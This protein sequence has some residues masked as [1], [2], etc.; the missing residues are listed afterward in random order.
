MSPGM[1]EWERPLWATLDVLRAQGAVVHD[2]ADYVFRL[3]V[4]KFL[5]DVTDGPPT[6][7]IPR[8]V[9][10]PSAHWS[11]LRSSGSPGLGDRVNKACAM[12]E[13]A[14]PSLSRLLTEEDFNSIRL[15]DRVLADL[16]QSLS[17]LPRLS[18]E[19]VSDGSLGEVANGFL[20]RLVETSGREYGQFYTPPSVARLMAELLDPRENMRIYDPFCGVGGFLV[21]CMRRVASSFGVSIPRAA[22]SLVLHGQEKNA[23]L[24]ALC[25]MNLL[26]HG[27][28][29]ARIEHGNALWSPL[30][31]EQGHMLQY[32]RVVADPPWSLR[33]WGA[34]WAS[35]DAFGRF[36][37]IP[38]RHGADYA[39][40]QHCLAALAEGGMAALLL[41]RGVLFR[42]GVE[43]H[44]R[45]KLLEEDRFEAI[46]GLPVNLLYY[47]S[48][49]PVVLILRKGKPT[50]RRNRVLFIDAS[51]AGG[52]K[53]RRRALA[54]EDI[55]AIVKAFQDFEGDRRHARAVHL[56]EIAR[57]NWNL[58]IER[59]VER[60]EERERLMLDEQL[61]ALA[62]AEK[63]RE[64]AARR[65]DASIS[66]LKRFCPSTS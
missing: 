45:R 14:N 48:I 36:D 15:G 53:G 17:A 24:W 26:L 39:F 13:E 10:P 41:P 18:G 4:L 56:D 64:E 6:P 21:E 57:S 54:R 33:D 66:R 51:E 19:R 7:G 20:H 46:I 35:K 65:M 23:E 37:P 55:G 40:V 16:L 63:Q 42:G 1:N 8:F 32:D 28:V 43:E 59:Y 61:D 34:E 25:R 29:D 12:L 52:R 62:D 27:I 2:A 38:P 3:L 47:T 49:A 58:N 30:V 50:N 60:E 5:S 9:V 22:A 44:I 31:T 11:N